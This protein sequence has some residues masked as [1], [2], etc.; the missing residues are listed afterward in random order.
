MGLTKDELTS[1][2]AGFSSADLR[3]A[4]TAVTEDGTVGERG[5]RYVRLTEDG[6]MPVPGSEDPTGG[7]GSG[8]TPE[9]VSGAE[10]KGKAAMGRAQISATVTFRLEDVSKGLDVAA[11][12]DARSLCTDL[13]NLWPKLDVS[14]ELAGVEVF[15]EPVRVWPPEG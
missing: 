13:A 4:L 6:E 15:A 5:G 12:E 9:A 10:N 11:I 14:V 2:V 1:R 7:N 8:T 3:E